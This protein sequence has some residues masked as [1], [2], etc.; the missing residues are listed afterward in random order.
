MW[1]TLKSK[2]DLLSELKVHYLNHS[3]SHTK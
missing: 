1:V 3:Y 2:P